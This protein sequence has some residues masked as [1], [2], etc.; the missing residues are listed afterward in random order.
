M[1]GAGN[2]DSLRAFVRV[3]D[4]SSYRVNISSKGKLINTT[5]EYK[6][7]NVRGTPLKRHP[8]R[9]RMVVKRLV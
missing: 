3:A 6:N 1:K 8:N 2:L 7:M 5:L 4:Q 9:H